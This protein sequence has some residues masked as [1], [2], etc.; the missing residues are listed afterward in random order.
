M[1][2]SNV[3]RSENQDVFERIFNHP[4]V[5]GIGQGEV[6]KEALAHYI[7]ADYEYLNAFM[8]VYGVAISKSSDRN[9]IQLF[10]EQIDFVLN[11]EVHPHHNFCEQIGIPYEEL[12]GFALPPTADHYIK[13]MLYHAH[14]GGIGEILAAL[15]PCPW[16]YLE[17]GQ[18]L[19]HTFKPDASHPFSLWIHF[20][21]EKEMKKLTKR[22]CSR[23]DEYAEQASYREKDR[24]REAFR[25]SCQLEYA[26]WEMA[27]T[28][29][30]WPVGEE[31]VR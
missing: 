11:S 21:A 28:E 17:I 15:L 31:A 24:M 22:L 13:H 5:Q 26:F 14:H 10:H 27:Y 6:S 23:L 18:E 30:K 4:F 12:Q 16:T 3:L 1:S 20:Y 2:F 19:M 8:H 25:K 9:D 7:K 29:E